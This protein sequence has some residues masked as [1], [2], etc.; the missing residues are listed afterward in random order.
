VFSSTSSITDT[1][2]G[3]GTE[4][5]GTLW[6]FSLWVVILVAVFTVGALATLLRSWVFTL[7]GERFVARLR[8]IVSTHVV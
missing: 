3:T 6:D 2:N 1:G 8:K 7:A 4:N 5:I